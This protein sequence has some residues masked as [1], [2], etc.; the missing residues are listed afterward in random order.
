MRFLCAERPSPTTI[1][2]MQKIPPGRPGDLQRRLFQITEALSLEERNLRNNPSGLLRAA[3]LIEEFFHAPDSRFPAKHSASRASIATTSKRC[4]TIFA[5]GTNPTGFSVRTTTRLRARW[6]R[7][8]TFPLRPSSSKPR[9]SS[10]S[11]RIPRATSATVW[12]FPIP[13]A[14]Q[15]I[16]DCWRRLE[17]R[18]ERNW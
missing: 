12:D 1:F 6:A 8:T 14:P 3:D 10:R 13:G 16:T 7:M 4:P 9:G 15:I 2:D 17:T 18:V 11:R 5:D